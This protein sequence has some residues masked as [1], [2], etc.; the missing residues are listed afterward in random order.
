[1]VSLILLMIC[2]LYAQSGRVTIFDQRVYDA[3]PNASG[4]DD[5]VGTIERPFVYST[6]GKGPFNYSIARKVHGYLYLGIDEA[7][8]S[9]K[10]QM[11][12]KNDY[13]GNGFTVCS[14]VTFIGGY[15][16]VSFPF[17]VGIDG[18]D[19]QDLPISVN[20]PVEFWQSVSIIR[21]AYG[22]CPTNGVLADIVE[23]FKFRKLE[24]QT[25]QNNSYV[26]NPVDPFVV[27]GRTHCI[28]RSQSSQNNAT[29]HIDSV[30]TSSL[31]CDDARSTA[32]DDIELHDNCRSFGNV[33]QKVRIEIVPTDTCR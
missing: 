19:T 30:Y 14:R 10:I 2:P 21:I 11:S 5:H 16:W 1:M 7:T 12:Y 20:Q 28:W 8:G 9:G 22:W 13:K 15:G 26:N 17:R 4:I 29:S 3:A 18:G 23:A 33:W 25:D 27:V 6:V 32:K 24:I 31:S